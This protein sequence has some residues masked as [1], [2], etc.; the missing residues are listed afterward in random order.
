MAA[1]GASIRVVAWFPAE[2]G[3]ALVDRALIAVIGLMI[4]EMGTWKRNLR[5]SSCPP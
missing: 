5:V 1:E 2:A 4:M 3:G